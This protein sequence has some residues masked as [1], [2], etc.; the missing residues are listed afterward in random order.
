MSGAALTAMSVKDHRD[1]AAW[2]L[3]NELRS[4]VFKLTSEG[5]ASTDFRFRSQTEDAVSSV[6]RNLPEG[7]YRFQPGE[8]SNFVRYAQASLAE[9]G[10][11]ITDGV[12]RNYWSD[13]QVDS[14]RALLRRAAGALGGLRRYLRSPRARRNAQRIAARDQRRDSP[15]PQGTQ[16]PEEPRN[17][18]NLRNPRNPGTQEP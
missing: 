4:L 6:C 10:E 8:F 2:Q 3:A 1:L 12:E 16:E 14:A 9:L 15:E 18:R 5:P 11:Q 13:E 7:F 17:P